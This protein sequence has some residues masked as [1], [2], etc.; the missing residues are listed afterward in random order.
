MDHIQEAGNPRSSRIRCPVSM[1]KSSCYMGMTL[2]QAKLRITVQS[3]QP[4]AK[5]RGHFNGGHSK[6]RK[7]RF[8]SVADHTYGMV[9]P[10]HDLHVNTATQMY[11]IHA[12]LPGR[13][14]V[15]QSTS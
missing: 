3:M 11:N 2:L 13:P 5:L 1:V 8:F 10:G 15:S 6:S 9:T 12:G 7:T 4:V 14:E